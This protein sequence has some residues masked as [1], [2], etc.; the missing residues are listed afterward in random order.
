MV[1][2]VFDPG[3]RLLDGA[4]LNSLMGTSPSL[5]R[6]NVFLQYLFESY[7]DNITATAG[8]GQTNAFQLSAEISRVN[9]VAT[10]GDSVALPPALPGLNVMVIN[11]GTKPMQVFGSAVTS[12]TINDVA[13]ATGVSQMQGSMVIYVCTTTG[14]WYSQGLGEGYSGS[15]MTL[16]SVDNLTAKAGGG[17]SGATPLTAMMNRVVTVAS[18]ADSVLLPAS[19]AGMNLTVINAHASNSM[20]MFPATG[21]TINALSANAA[22]AVAAGKTVEVYC[23]SAGQWHTILSA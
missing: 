10:A 23:V 1:Q 12:D 18:A 6:L 22:F 8:G 3:L 9:T 13:T 20:N 19:A 5:G 15:Y 4:V 7:V 21:E 14:K 2:P 16:S 11:H 17:Q